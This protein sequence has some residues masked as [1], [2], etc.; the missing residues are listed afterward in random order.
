MPWTATELKG[1]SAKALVGKHLREHQEF[2]R[3][4][5]AGRV[6]PGKVEEIVAAHRQLAREMGRRGLKHASPLHRTA[7]KSI[8]AL[9]ADLSVCQLCGRRKMV[10]PEGSATAK[11]VVV[12]E[13]PGGEEVKRGRPFVGEAG[14]RLA[15]VLDSLGLAR[16]DVYLTNAVKCYLGRRPTRG[17][18]EA[19]RPWLLRELRLVGKGKRVVA[20]GKVAARAL[21]GTRVRRAPHP[22][23]RQRRVAARIRRA[24]G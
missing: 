13:S 1:M 14:R 8:A 20:L 21:A 18:I 12:G 11:T 5:R 2:V 7:P 24:L 4:E 9:K 15:K 10:P 19:C 17:E 22:V 3:Q 23:A 6:K 16:G